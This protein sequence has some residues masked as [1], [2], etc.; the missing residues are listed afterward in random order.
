MTKLIEEMRTLAINE[1]EQSSC[2]KTT[3][4]AVREKMIGFIKEETIW[5]YAIIDQTQNRIAI[6]VRDDAKSQFQMHEIKLEVTA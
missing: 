6:A 4:D 5:D 1:F 3:I 2:K